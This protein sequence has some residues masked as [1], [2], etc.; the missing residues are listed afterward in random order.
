MPALELVLIGTGS[1]VPSPNRSGPSQV[2]TGGDTRV[3]IDCGWGAT[4]RLYAAR[5]PPISISAVFF[6]HL[7]SDHITDLADF[8]MMRWTGGATKPLPVY[9][10]AGTAEMV[11]GFRQALAEDKKF[12]L[13]HHGEKLSSIGTACDVTEI[14][15]GEEPTAVARTGDVTV[16]AFAVD[17]RPVIPAYGYRLERDGYA[18]AVSGDTNACPGLTAGARGADILV[19]DSQHREMMLAFEDSLRKMGNDLVAALLFDAH[20][21]HASTHDAA[22]VAQTAGVKHLVMSHV[23]PPIPD[24]GTEV[25]AFTAGL[26]QIYSG[27]ITVGRD[28]QRFVLPPA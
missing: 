20:T 26:S 2:I 11:G 24:E 10:P 21:Y 6:T 17:H 9:G 15:A 3:L 28:L 27:R 4:R 7:H 14:T 25:E 22:R 1:P 13:A 8:L 5:I 19:C 23:M 12:R 18:V 16:S